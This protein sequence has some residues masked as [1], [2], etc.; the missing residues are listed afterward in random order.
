[1]QNDKKQPEPRFSG[2]QD[3]NNTLLETED[4]P[5]EYP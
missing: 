1:M 2:N 4:H 5:L 3:Y